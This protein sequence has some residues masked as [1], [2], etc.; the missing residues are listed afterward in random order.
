M[1]QLLIGQ[2]REYRSRAQGQ[3]TCIISDMQDFML[4]ATTATQKYKVHLSCRL[5]ATQQI[6]NR[7]M[8]RTTCTP[9]PA[10]GKIKNSNNFI[11]LTLKSKNLPLIMVFH[12]KCLY[13]GRQKIIFM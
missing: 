6:V 7:W 2:N 12:S 8:E 5:N 4:T 13:G 11:L 10:I 1:G 3:D 9:A